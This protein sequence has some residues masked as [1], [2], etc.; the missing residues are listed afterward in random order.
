[1]VS[2]SFRRQ[3]CEEL[4]NYLGQVDPERD[5]GMERKTKMVKLEEH[6]TGAEKSPK[7]EAGVW[8]ASGFGF[9]TQL[10]FAN[11]LIM[12]MCLISPSLC[13][14][15]CTCGDNTCLPMLL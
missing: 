1:M 6:E 2:E 3:A 8:V 10:S 11:C 4:R 5:I 13:Y 14:H 15:I 9:E 7:Q 12:A